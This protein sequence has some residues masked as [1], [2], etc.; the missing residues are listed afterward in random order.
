MVVKESV[1]EVSQVVERVAL[2]GQG[3][4]VVWLLQRVQDLVGVVHGFPEQSFSVNCQIK[5]RY[6]LT[7]FR[8]INILLIKEYNFLALQTSLSTCTKILDGKG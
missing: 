4:G 1:F 8:D 2:D 6:I 7:L 3:L 5:S